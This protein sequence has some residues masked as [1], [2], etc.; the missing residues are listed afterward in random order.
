MLFWFIA[1]VV[2]AVACVALL[3]AGAGRRVN[4]ADPQFAQANAQFATVLARIEAEEAS[5]VLG[6][7]EA[8][9]AK[10]ELAREVLRF[11]NEAKGRPGEGRELG[12]TPLLLGLGAVAAIS[13][14]TY[15]FLGNPELPSQPLAER[16][17]E[18]RQ[19]VAVNDAVARIEAQL[20]QHPEDLRGWS[21]IAPAYV[22]LGWYDDAENA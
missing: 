1:T 5:G 17:E 11:K 21:V 9:G 14:A 16:A 3:Y 6:A 19:T 4:A 12:R 10:A 22:T 20:A 13:L 8:A 7:E 18:T 2:T 15:G